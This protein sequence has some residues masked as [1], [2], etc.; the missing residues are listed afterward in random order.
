VFGGD[1]SK[2]TRV[3]RETIKV[4][5]VRNKWEERVNVSFTLKLEREREKVFIWNT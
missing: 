2:R 3:W 4:V 5:I 1:G